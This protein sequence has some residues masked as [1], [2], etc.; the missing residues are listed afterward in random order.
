MQERRPQTAI[1]IKLESL[2]ITKFLAYGLCSL[3]ITKSLA[4]RLCLKQ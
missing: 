4:Y 2:Y 1:G 3:Y